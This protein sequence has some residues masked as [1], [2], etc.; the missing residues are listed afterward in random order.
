VFVDVDFHVSEARRRDAF[1]SDDTRPQ[2]HRHRV[3]RHTFI[4]EGN[5]LNEAIDLG[6]VFSRD[7]MTEISCSR[8]L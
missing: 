8:V 1:G 7:P 4:F 6:E 3:T 2:P 5:C